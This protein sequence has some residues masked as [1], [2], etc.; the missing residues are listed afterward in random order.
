MHIRQDYD[1]AMQSHRSS[2]T[3]FNILGIYSLRAVKQENLASVLKYL[4][5]TQSITNRSQEFMEVAT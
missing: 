2:P 4:L 3:I 1:M 5:G